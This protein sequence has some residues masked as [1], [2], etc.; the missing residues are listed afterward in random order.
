MGTN[1]RRMQGT[2][3]CSRKGRLGDCL[4]REL[5]FIRRI[6]V[7][8]RLAKRAVADTGIRYKYADERRRIVWLR[9]AQIFALPDYA[10]AT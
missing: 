9:H 5:A 1:D 10:A 6:P 2:Y 3:R 8:R 4:P 7:A